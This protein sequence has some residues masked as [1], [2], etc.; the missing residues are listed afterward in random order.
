MITKRCQ[1]M[2]D[3]WMRSVRFGRFFK[4]KHLHL[5]G[6][7]G[8]YQYALPKL[9]HR[10]LP[11]SPPCFPAKQL[12]RCRNR[13]LACDSAGAGS[14]RSREP[15]PAAGCVLAWRSTS[16]KSGSASASGA[17]SDVAKSGAEKPSDLESTTANITTVTERQMR[18][19]SGI[20]LRRHGGDHQRLLRAAGEAA[21]SGRG[22]RPLGGPRSQPEVDSQG[23]LSDAQPLHLEILVLLLSWR[24]RYQTSP[25][26]VSAS[27]VFLTS[28]C[29]DSWITCRQLPQP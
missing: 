18:L 10:M 21:G 19:M 15:E 25:C 28:N 29:C 3:A 2:R 5:G 8:A 20:P 27:V 12:S 11:M 26:P 9:L 6:S 13:R 17:V 4:S 1:I 7:S 14:E 16:S 23:R 24:L 22:T